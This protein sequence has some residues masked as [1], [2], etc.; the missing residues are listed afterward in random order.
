MQKKKIVK[1]FKEKKA[2]IRIHT[3]IPNCSRYLKVCKVNLLL[4]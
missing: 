4:K 2:E 3:T 1:S